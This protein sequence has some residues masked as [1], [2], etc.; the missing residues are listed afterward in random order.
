M[1][2]KLLMFFLNETFPNL[3]IYLLLSHGLSYWKKML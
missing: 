3:S 1:D 2:V